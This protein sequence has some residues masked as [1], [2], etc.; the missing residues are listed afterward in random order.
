M[1]QIGGAH[2]TFCQ[3]DAILLQKYRNRSGRRIAVLFKSIRVR[4]RFDSSDNQE[5]DNPREGQA[6]FSMCR[7]GIVLDPGS[8][9]SHLDFCFPLCLSQCAAS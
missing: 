1:A 7:N 4:C 2:T 6:A 9:L 8:S 5:E 3:E